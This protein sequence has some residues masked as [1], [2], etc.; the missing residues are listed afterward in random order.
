MC[1]HV[2]VFHLKCHRNFFLLS[3]AEWSYTVSDSISGQNDKFISWQFD[4]WW[5]LMSLAIC[6]FVWTLNFMLTL[7][8]F[9]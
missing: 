5:Q 7:P 4:D 8:L 2:K 1:C 3:L 6:F 9:R